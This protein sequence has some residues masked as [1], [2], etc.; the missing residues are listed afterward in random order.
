[1]DSPRSAA[2]RAN[3]SIL[4]EYTAALQHCS[5][6]ALQHCSTAHTT[7]ICLKLHIMSGKMHHICS[8]RQPVHYCN[9]HTLHFL[10]SEKLI[11][12]LFWPRD[13]PLCLVMGMARPGAARCR[14]PASSV[15]ITEA[16]TVTM[17]WLLLITSLVPG[18]GPHYEAGA[19]VPALQDRP[20]PD[21]W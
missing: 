2:A 8:H 10:C 16:L 13:S 21:T 5:T 15:V 14:P 3:Y 20:T 6:A 1:M 18:A 4:I 17:W 9:L 19:I 11:W 7:S 12:A